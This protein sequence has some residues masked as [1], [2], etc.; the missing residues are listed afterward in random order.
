[1]RWIQG[2]PGT[3]EVLCNKLDHDDKFMQWMTQQ[4]QNEVTCTERD[5]LDDDAPDAFD[6]WVGDLNDTQAADFLTRYEER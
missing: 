6:D 1:M 3:A 4:W 5:V 2:N